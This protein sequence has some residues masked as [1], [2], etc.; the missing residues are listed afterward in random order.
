MIRGLIAALIGSL[1][2]SMMFKNT[3]KKMWI[4]AVGGCLTWGLYLILQYFG[5]HYIM[6]NFISAAF[7]DIYAE[8]MARFLKAPAT[9]FLIPSV[10]PLIPG[11]S[12]Y[13]TMLYAVAKD[14]INFTN[15]GMQTFYTAGAIAVGVVLVSVIFKLYGGKVILQE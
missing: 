15:M 1:G 2:Y 8:L 7:G 6:A 14:T 12:L 3:G 9:I 10:V 4:A 11:G 5:V 13:Y